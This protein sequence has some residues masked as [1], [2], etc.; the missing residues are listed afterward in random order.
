LDEN[1]TLGIRK[2]VQRQNIEDFDPTYTKSFG[3]DV[4]LSLRRVLSLSSRLFVSPL[5][6][7]VFL[8]PQRFV[9]HLIVSVLLYKLHMD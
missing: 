7:T 5:T 9:I 4:V 3:D 2:F 6:S 1:K 8:H